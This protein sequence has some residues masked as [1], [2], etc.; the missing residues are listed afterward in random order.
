MPPRVRDEHACAERPALMPRLVPDVVAT[1]ETREDLVDGGLF[2]A[3]ERALGVVAPGRRREFVTGRACARRALARLAV[4]PTPIAIGE[5][6]E[7]RWPHGLVG[8]IT[9]CE[10]YRACAIARAT[11]VAALGIDAEPNAPLPARLLQRVA[12]ERELAGVRGCG[13]RSERVCSDRLLFSAKEAVYKAWFSLTR[14]WLG[15]RDVELSLDLQRASLRAHL[16]V[17]PPTVDGA[18]LATL[19][20]RWCVEDG[21]LC[22]AVVLPRARDTARGR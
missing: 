12:S 3:E 8:S 13:P 15:F 16:L 6:R 1:A 4:A 2:A 17:A 18:E 22:V 9:H 7:P 20:G 10:G 11:D 14:R 21:I 19:E 5:R